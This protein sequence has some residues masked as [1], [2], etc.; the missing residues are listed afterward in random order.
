MV[1]K[2]A[3]GQPKISAAQAA[4]ELGISKRRVLYLLKEGRILGAERTPLGYLIPSPVKV[5][6]AKFGP[7]PSF[8]ERKWKRR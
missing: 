8:D 2:K 6:V 3:S 4:D 5:K 1:A 7:V